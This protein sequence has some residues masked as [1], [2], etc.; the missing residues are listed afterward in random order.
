MLLLPAASLQGGAARLAELEYFFN[1]QAASTAQASAPAAARS[2]TLRTLSS[3][4]GYDAEAKVRALWVWD[5]SQDLP[6]VLDD[7]SLLNRWVD[8]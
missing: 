4:P 6:A 2:G 5:L 7:A 1:G 8:V 3:G